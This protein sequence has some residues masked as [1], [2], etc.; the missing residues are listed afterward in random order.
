[1]K[2]TIVGMTATLALI[3]AGCAK[4]E[5]AEALTYEGSSTISENILP[6]L[7]AG[8]EKRTGVRFEKIGNA[9]SAEGF[10]A[11]MDG[12]AAL[13]G[14]SRELKVDERVMRPR[15]Q[16][17]GHDAIAIFVNAAN[18]V[19]NLSLDQLRDVFAGKITNWKALGG[20]DRPIVVVS[21]QLS[22]TR[23]TL[24]EL[25]HLV[26]AEQPIKATREVD[27]PHDC[28]RAV[29]GEPD[30]I[31]YG[32][33]AFREPGVEPVS[34]DGVPPDTQS[35]RS[36][37]YPLSRPLL[38]VTRAAP[39]GAVKEFLDYVLS[40]EGQAMVGKKFVRAR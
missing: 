15:Y 26:M 20:P 28:V 38:L 36:R 40:A 8:F 35:V 14:L 25:R 1:M 7:T 16:V 12:R 10:K 33:I 9:G 32:S 18:P 13:G 11:A 19:R 3:A 24:A 29:A 23:G 4:E 27:L 6:E 30:A 22:G 39:T 17:I 5:K 21:E 34:L 37:A 2:R 31:S